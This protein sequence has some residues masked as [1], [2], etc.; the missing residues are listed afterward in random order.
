VIVYANSKSEELFGYHYGELVGTPVTALDAPGNE[1]QDVAA[2]MFTALDQSGEWRGEVPLAR[3]DGTSFW[4]DSSIS[5]FG[6]AAHGRV[7]VSVHTD[8]TVRKGMERQFQ[9][10]NDRL[11]A[12]VSERTRELR[13]AIDDLS[14]EILERK[15]AQEALRQSQVRLGSVIS[16]APVIL[17]AIGASGV[18]TLSEGRGLESL[19][20][21]LG[22]LVGRSVFEVHPGA[23][24]RAGR[25]RHGCDRRIHSGHGARA[26]GAEAGHFSGAFRRDL[27]RPHSTNHYV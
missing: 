6:H 15:L 8:I 1:R 9:D 5:A 26:G 14:R 2:E 23:G 21:E 27:D 3:K 19:G 10:A 18:F 24:S 25:L 20:F 7:R 11:E 16:Q 17:W 22:E 4:C 12:W 13:S